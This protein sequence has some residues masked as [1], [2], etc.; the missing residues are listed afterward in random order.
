MEARRRGRA[1]RQQT[2]QQRLRILHARPDGRRLQKAAQL[3]PESKSWD[4]WLKAQGG[5]RGWRG[6]EKSSWC[7]SLVVIRC[8]FYFWSHS[9]SDLQTDA[10]EQNS[11]PLFVH[12]HN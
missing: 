11:A 10:A 2:N 3:R 8:C 6:Y 1:H 5:Q 4:I 12:Q 7:V 9:G